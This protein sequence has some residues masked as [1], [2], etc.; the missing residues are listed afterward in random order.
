M[1][2]TCAQEQRTTPTDKHVGTFSTFRDCNAA[3]SRGMANTHT[4]THMHESRALGR[5]RYPGD[6]ER[7]SICHPENGIS[8]KTA[9]PSA[10][11]VGSFATISCM[12][13]AASVRL[14][15][16]YAL[17]PVGR[18]L[19]PATAPEWTHGGASRAAGP[20]ARH[21][22]GGRRRQLPSSNPSTM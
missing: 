13:A 6:M 22:R 21:Y 1:C 9:L 5:N 8:N 18:G 2:L 11:A 16:S 14:V 15:V 4:H 7:I 12:A 3:K 10:V 19:V 17:L 20:R